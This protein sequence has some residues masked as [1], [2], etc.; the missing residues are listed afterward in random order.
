MKNRLIAVCAVLLALVLLFAGCGAA[1]SGGKRTDSYPAAPGYAADSSNYYDDYDSPESP[2]YESEWK[3]DSGSL[4]ELT[5]GMMNANAN[6]EFDKIIYT[7]NVDLETLE[8]E[9]TIAALYKLIEANGAFIETS[10]V[11]G[12]NYNAKYYYGYSSY[13]TAYFTIRVPKE[14]FAGLTGS[15]S[16]I[17]NVTQS[18]TSADN[19][20]SSF[21][22]TE[23]RLKAYRTEESNLLDMMEK[24]DT[25]ED[26][27]T[28]QDRLSWVRYEIE[29][30]TSQLNNW[31]RRVDY[32]TLNLNV[33]EV[34]EYTEEPVEEKT[35]GEEIRD[36]FNSSVKWL[37]QALRDIVVF[38]VSA[39][40]VLVLPL[41]ILVPAGIILLIVLLAVRGHKK[42]AKKNAAEGK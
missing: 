34:K 12:T 10:S 13:R 39:L 42:K 25:V 30:L 2:S 8:F 38:V 14:N 19:I 1:S 20:T 28:I 15:L 21:L 11:S 37:K 7:A 27:I 5:E 29:S 41:I 3:G 6:S 23:S 18:R 9:E 32:S 36:G 4:G 24:A 31:Q 35:F 40:P 26:M 16:S 17:G 33:T 22:D